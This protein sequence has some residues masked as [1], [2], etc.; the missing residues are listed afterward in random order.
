MGFDDLFKYRKDAR[1]SDHG[2]Y[3]GQQNF[4]HGHLGGI[5]KYIY[6]YEKLRSNRKLLKFL[7]IGFIVAVIAV[8][9]IAIALAVMLIPLITE[10]FGA[11][12]KNGIGGIVETARPW[13]ELLW[14]GSEK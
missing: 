9:V 4:H 6:L 3:G 7:V 10:L 2:Y 5:Q 12:Q 11:I 8:V 1:Y 14:S 13:L